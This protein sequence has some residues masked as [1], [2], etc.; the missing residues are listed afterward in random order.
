[1]K[2]SLVRQLFN[3]NKCSYWFPLYLIKVLSLLLY[4]VNKCILSCFSIIKTLQY[5][6]Y[7]PE[8][9][10]ADSGVFPGEPEGTG[11]AGSQEGEGAGRGQPLYYRL[12]YRM[13]YYHQ[14]E[15]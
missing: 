6:H 4:T 8:L 3:K 11:D 7:L 5:H 13:L 14:S 12:H 15:S 9:A 1:M 10:A 2:V